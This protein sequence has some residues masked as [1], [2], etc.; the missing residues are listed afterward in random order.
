MPNISASAYA[1]WQTCHRLFYWQ[2]V[3]KLERVRDDGA[4]RFG[5]MYHAGLEAWWREMDGGDVPWR[6]KDA[7]LVAAISAIAANAK[8]IDTD[9]FE[10]ARRRGDDAPRGTRATSSSTS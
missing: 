2:H 10:V 7:A 6:D 3:I 8:H 9:P 5:T 4:R 1:H